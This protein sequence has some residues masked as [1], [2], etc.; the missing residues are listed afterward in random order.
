MESL[1]WAYN[2]FVSY[3]D[4]HSATVVVPVDNCFRLR[5]FYEKTVQKWH[6]NVLDI[7]YNHDLW[8]RE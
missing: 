1:R 8:L 4:R 2:I 3:I 7:R 6:K 5:W